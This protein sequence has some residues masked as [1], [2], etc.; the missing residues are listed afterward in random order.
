M[1]PCFCTFGPDRGGGGGAT[2]LMVVQAFEMRRK[3]GGGG[4]FVL[5]RLAWNGRGKWGNEG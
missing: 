2:E 3:G 5:A 4:R 1:N